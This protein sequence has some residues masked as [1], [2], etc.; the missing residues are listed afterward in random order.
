VT[1]D[2]TSFT[3]LSGNPTLEELAAVTAVIEAMIEEQGDSDR[4]RVG[5]GM[6]AWQ[7]SQRSVREPLRPGF[8]AWRS[9]SGK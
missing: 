3:V 7:R 4:R 6:S 1:A 9:F 8:G 2:E 5:H